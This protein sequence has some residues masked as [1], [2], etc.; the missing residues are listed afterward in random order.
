MIPDSTAPSL[1]MQARHEA[2]L[3]IRLFC[4]HPGMTVG[5]KRRF[6]LANERHHSLHNCLRRAVIQPHYPVCPC[7]NSAILPG[8]SMRYVVFWHQSDK[9]AFT[10]VTCSAEHALS[11]S[12]GLAE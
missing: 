10:H 7:G 3:P 5:V 12:E 2:L 6:S 4:I 1:P 11:V 8:V 9:D